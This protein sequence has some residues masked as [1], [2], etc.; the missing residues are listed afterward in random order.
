[1]DGAG[2]T[3]NLGPGI[4]DLDDD[5][6]H[7][8]PAVTPSLSAGAAWSIIDETPL[9]VW[10][11]SRRFNPFWEP[12]DSEKFD[13]GKAAHEVLTTKGEGIWRVDEKDWRTKAAKEARD[14]ARAKGFV[15]LLGHQVDRVETMIEVLQITMTDLGIGNPFGNPAN[16]E[17]TVIWDAGG[18]LNRLKVDTCDPHLRVA[19]D[20]KTAA[21]N[22]PENWL[23]TNMDHGIALRTAHYLEGLQAAWPGAPWTYRF[24]VQ[25]KGKNSPHTVSFIELPESTIDLGRHQL[26]RAREMWNWCVERDRWPGRPAQI[27]M[28]QHPPW[29]ETR[30]IERAD[31]DRHHKEKYGKDVLESWFNFQAGPGVEYTGEDLT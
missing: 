13:F 14:E 27:A 7:G 12:E 5:T 22:D 18:T 10:S 2:S 9:H 11:N 31:A 25:E 24:I 16:N 21:D 20:Y 30:W 19:Y 23:K 1:M 6:Y 29:S 26:A 17:R 3:R 15:P 4:Y 28:P 8:D